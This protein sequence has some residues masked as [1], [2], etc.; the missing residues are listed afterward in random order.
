MT[1][2]KLEKVVN[3]WRNIINI[4]NRASVTHITLFVRDLLK[5]A[6]YEDAAYFTDGLATELENMDT[7]EIAKAQIWKG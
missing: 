2:N 7:A 6:G 5:E 4:P 1:V 3:D